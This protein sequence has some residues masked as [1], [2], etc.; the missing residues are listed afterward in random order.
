MIQDDQET[1]DESLAQGLATPLDLK[2]IDFL[3]GQVLESR[4]RIDEEVGRGGMGIVYRG[5]DLT[6]SRPVTIKT[7]LH[8]QSDEEGLERFIREA[9]TLAQIEHTKL[10]PVYAVGQDEG[11]HYLVMKFLEGET[12]SARL[13][14]EGALSPSFTRSVVQ[15]VCEAL[16]ALHTQNLIHRDIKPANLMISPSGGV[17]V[18]DLGIVKHVGEES[19][20]TSS[21][22]IG[23]PRYMPPEAVDSR[24]LDP[25]AD[26]YSLGVIAYQMLVGEPPF[27]GPTPMSILYQQAHVLPPRV[28][29]KVPSTPKN[30]ESAIEVSLQKNP[31]E[32]FQNAIEMAKAFDESTQFI[33][34][35]QGRFKWMIVA[36][37]AG[38]LGAL[39]LLNQDLLQWEQSAGRLT[40]LS[41]STSGVESRDLKKNGTERIILDKSLKNPIVPRE[42]KQKRKHKGQNK[43]SV[44]S[45]E[46][47]RKGSAV[48]E[49]PKFKESNKV[50]VRLNSQPR[51]AKIYSGSKFIGRT[52][53]TLTKTKGETK[54]YTL[55]L[56][57]FKDHPLVVRDRNVKAQMKSVFGGFN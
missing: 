19:N 3:I 32:R 14:K 11:Y 10:V 36:F 31:E 6:L 39:L 13:R 46:G 28:R 55:K 43:T 15:Q 21:F 30:L 17:T 57:G 35:G 22:A 48:S 24:P 47:R 40:S 8:S 53:F 42:E 33:E 4:Y 41:E 52:P 20:T 45:S 2:A 26:L 29:E 50:K 5:T 54:V 27:N 1:V 49:R 44:S 9:K 7:I 25:R 12:L 16:N 56:K 18:M 34:E 37:V 23:T 38:I 51:N